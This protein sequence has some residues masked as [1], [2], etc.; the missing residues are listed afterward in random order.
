MASRS[1]PVTPE[2]LLEQSSW[3][4]RLAST[5]VGGDAAEDLMQ[6]TWLAALRNPPH[7]AGALRPWLARIARN[8]ASNLARGR[9]RRASHE[10][11]ASAPGAE[12]DPL[13]VA[14]AVEGQRVL[15]EAVL[16]LEEPLRTT[17]VLRY[18]RGLDSGAIARL[19]GVPAGTVRWR[20]KRALLLLRAELDRRYGGERALWSTALAALLPRAASDT[21]SPS[22]PRLAPAAG[23]APTL[24]A[25]ATLMSTAMKIGAAAVALTAL[26]TAWMVI[27]GDGETPEAL[28]AGAAIETGRAPRTSSPRME[29]APGPGSARESLPVESRTPPEAAPPV[30]TVLDCCIVG[31]VLDLEGR[32]IPGAQVSAQPASLGEWTLRAKTA[33]EMPAGR[34]TSGEDGL[35]RLEVP[36]LRPFVL[37]ARHQ[38]CAPSSSALAF[39][40]E[41]HDLTLP[42]GTTLTIR[43]TLG[44]GVPCAGA[45]V[46]VRVPTPDALAELWTGEASTDGEGR[47]VLRGL[48]AGKA[49]I[50]AHSRDRRGV[51]LL[52]VDGFTALSCELELIPGGRLEGTVVDRVTLLPVP[53]AR[54][55][56]RYHGVEEVETD[57]LGRYAIEGIGIGVGLWG[58][59][60]H[61][62]GYASGYE[63]VKLSP[64]E[65]RRRVDFALEPAV[66]A[67]GSVLDS[68]GRPVAGARL[69][70]LAALST[71][72]FEGTTDRCE[73]AT[74]AR[75]RFELEDLQPAVEYRVLVHASGFAT[76]VFACGP[77]P[78]ASEPVE[79]DAFALE[80]GGAIAGEAPAALGEPHLVRLYWAGE[81]GPADEHL[82]HLDSTRTDPS[83]RFAFDSLAP[84]RYRLALVKP[85]TPEFS[86][87]FAPPAEALV[88]LAPGEERSGI[89]LAAGGESLSGTVVDGS[90]A[91]LGMCRVRVFAAGA[92]EKELAGTL[93]EGDG[94]FRLH[95][96][97]PGPF[98]VVAEDPRLFFDSA[99]LEPVEAGVAELRIVLAEFL[100]EHEIHG[101]LLPPSGQAP[102]NLFVSFTDTTT[103]ER[104]QRV[105]LPE[106]DGSFTM[107]NLRDV[108]YDLELVDFEGLFE[109]VRLPAIRPG[110][111][112]VVLQLE[113][114]R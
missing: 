6:E 95:V 5:L 99:A 62:H 101:R 41:R 79:L 34:T 113:P 66:H 107:K 81:H 87:L 39:A 70:W 92:P 33:P 75:G 26:V 60:V 105:A 4:R 109:A 69:V 76:G 24:T 23:A 94:R 65:P 7:G 17:V 108:P 106:P 98:R 29:P 61:A 89:V 11:G 12:L 56:S 67:G 18:S 78:A 84:G 48:P 100:S 16:A 36:G 55:G 28:G 27:D 54:V 88:V 19:Q 46:R 73:A 64:G 58:L 77:F 82:S 35:F 80:T 25:G 38:G 72:P 44:E 68:C 14:E 2:E 85:A 50:E 57:A 49:E 51:R 21:G 40:G 71:G 32:G 74:D 1:S 112:E 90:G 97:D 45:R 91:P 20:L 3:L 31:R 15:A 114:Q 13:L 53:G 63:N 37:T 93:S 110:D 8:L 10:A 83:G 103:G 59:E 9:S 104:L 30:P 102:E 52:E 96:H 42:S 86:G 22:H 111:R 43:A 47:A